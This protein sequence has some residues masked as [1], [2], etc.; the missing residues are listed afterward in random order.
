MIVSVLAC[1]N[2]EKAKDNNGQYIEIDDKFEEFGLIRYVP[3]FIYYYY[4]L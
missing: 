1:F 3:Q 4:F 2:I